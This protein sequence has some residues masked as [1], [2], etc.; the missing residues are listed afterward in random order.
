MPRMRLDLASLRAR[1]TDGGLDGRLTPTR[2]V[3][4]LFERMDASDGM[5][6]WIT[7][8]SRA[9]LYE[10]AML[11]ERESNPERRLPLWG[12]PF[13]VKDNID[14]AGLP[15]TAACPAFAYV[16]KTSAPVVRRLQAAG[17]LCVGKTNL[18]QFATGLTGTRSPYGVPRNPFDERHVVGG[19]SSGSA[20][21]VARGL[22]SFALGT[23]TAGS[24]R[25]PAGFTNTVGLKPSRGLL[26][27]D[28]VVPACRS[29]DCVSIFALTVADATLVADVASATQAFSGALLPP[30]FRFAVPDGTLAQVVASLRALGGV[31]AS[32]DFE[33]FA[34]AGRLLYD[35]PWI[36]ERLAGLA[37][38][39]TER[40]DALLPVTREILRAG[41]KVRGTDVFTGL[42][43]LERLRARVAPVWNELD[44]LVVPSAPMLPTIAEVDADAIG[45]NTRLGQYAT[46]VN[47]LDLAALAVPAGFRADGLPEG[48]TMI[49]PHGSDARLAALAAAFHRH[50]GGQLGATGWPM[51][52]SDA[53][54]A[55]DESVPAVS[56]QVHDDELAVAVVGAHLS[57]QPLNYQLR[58]RGA[59]FVA[60]TRTASCYRLH[61]LGP[62]PGLVRSAGPGA[63]IEVEV[64][65]M[66]RAQVGSF[67]AVMPPP[68]CLGSV[69]LADGTRVTGFLCEAHALDGARDI[70]SFGGWRAYLAATT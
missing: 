23:D 59:R 26:P 53:D 70:T 18:D 64:W 57:G 66:P 2:M 56:V 68:L 5:A 20:A 41:E 65:A 16:P 67:L 27:T 58:G 61:A 3:E 32:V 63:A 4:W 39:V 12:V 52:A 14:V 29:L 40:G 11:L 42:H 46:F 24:G 62:R 33:P 51:L 37:A 47:L 8:A 35:G 54:D 50:V 30:S 10:Q 34:A 6:I 9:Q 48:I 21:A 45:V 15:T 49:G 13:A 7:C 55:D 44:V 60:A 17:A 19:S 31:Q 69:E 43:Q 38:F 25:V 28:G 1:Y 22:V 36:A